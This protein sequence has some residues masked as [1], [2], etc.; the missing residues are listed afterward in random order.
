MGLKTTRR[1]TWLLKSPELTAA[2]RASPGCDLPLFPIRQDF[3]LCLLPDRLVEASIDM[4]RNVHLRVLLDAT[5]AG[6]GKFSAMAI[7]GSDELW[8]VGQK[9]L[10]HSDG[11]L[12]GFEARNL[13]QEFV[14]PG[15]VQIHSLRAHEPDENGITLVADTDGVGMQ[16]QVHFDSRN[17]ETHPFGVAGIQFA[18]AGPDHTFW[19][20]ASNALYS[21]HDGELTAVTNLSPRLYGDVSMGWRGTFWL[22]TSEGLLRFTPALWRGPEPG[23]MPNSSVRRAAAGDKL[24]DVAAELI[25]FDSEVRPLETVVTKTGTFQAKPLGLLREGRMCFELAVP[26][27]RE[28][29]P[30]LGTLDGTDFRPLP[31]HPL[32]NR[33]ASIDDYTC[34]LETLTGDIWLGGSFGVARLHNRWTVFPKAGNSYDSAQRRQSC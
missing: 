23:A 6:I 18:W 34:I 16:T 31:V 12:R 2:I 15:P 20:A 17:W 13:W 24:A 4:S 7:D 3:V 5:N 30:R 28:K 29:E 21:W 9:G 19:A 32:Q 11:P 27:D 10:C 1:G 8:I 33:E 22:A 14:L 26:A 25:S